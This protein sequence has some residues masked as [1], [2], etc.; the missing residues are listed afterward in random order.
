MRDLS[1]I[2]F[3][4]AN[5]EN[6]SR[7]RNPW[8]KLEMCLKTDKGDA[9]LNSWC[10]R[11]GTMKASRWDTFGENF[12]FTVSFLTCLLYF[13]HRYALWNAWKA[14]YYFLF[15]FSF[16]YVVYILFFF[17]LPSDVEAVP[18]FLVLFLTPN[19]AQQYLPLNSF[20][21]LF[22]FSYFL[23]PSSSFTSYLPLINSWCSRYIVTLIMILSS[24]LFQSPTYFST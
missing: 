11:K 22:H 15:S 12:N 7:K 3:L 5:G 14:L 4:L 6:F 20:F 17:Y 23:H 24:F 19:C 21:H 10:E 8:N 13:F 16:Y 9:K 2:S 1:F 18:I